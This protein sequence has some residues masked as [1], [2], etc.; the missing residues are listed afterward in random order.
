M[1]PVGTT[2]RSRALLLAAALAAGAGP[3]RPQTGDPSVSVS[4]PQ[5]VLGVPGPVSP[6]SVVPDAVQSAGF[7]SSLAS[8]TGTVQKMPAGDAPAPAAGSPTWSPPPGTANSTLGQPQVV[9]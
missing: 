8:T 1:R 2:R 4:A 7:R 9:N 3:L 6:F 5:P